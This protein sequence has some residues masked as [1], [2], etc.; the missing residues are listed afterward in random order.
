MQSII[1]AYLCLA[2]SVPILEAQECRPVYQGTL[3]VADGGEAPAFGSDVVLTDDEAFVGAQAAVIDGVQS[4]AVYIYALVGGAWEWVGRI[5]PPDARDGQLF[6]TWISVDGDTMMIGSPHDDEMGERSGSV[7]VYERHDGDWGFV[8]KLLPSV[9]K[10]L[11][12]F[13]YV[14]HRGG[15]AVI[16][17]AAKIYGDIEG[18][19][20][21]FE[22]DG[23]EWVETQRLT[24]SDG[25]PGEVFGLSP[26]FDDDWLMMGAPFARNELSVPN[27]ACY[28]FRRQNGAWV[29]TQVLEPD[30]FDFGHT[31]GF[32][33]ALEGGRLLVGDPDAAQHQGEVVAYELDAGVWK[34]A[35]VI[36]PEIDGLM[37]FGN[38][39]AMDGSTLLIGAPDSGMNA[40]AA[41]MYSLVEGDWVYIN[42]VVHA[43]SDGLSL[44]GA[45]LD[46]NAQTMMIAAPLD[47]VDAGSVY[48]YRLVCE[49]CYADLNGDGAMN[50]ADVGVFMAAF[51][52]G[53]LIADF[54]LDGELDFFDASAFLVAFNAGCP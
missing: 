3:S 30:V 42:T 52:A 47:D 46:I 19:A 37:G 44:F 28:V 11:G 50:A 10:E 26:V 25:G 45:M 39:L 15:M 41:G 2:V 38:Q 32:D 53:S 17:A 12:A 29:E 40:G 6:G 9:G 21:V 16:G 36:M 24:A 51:D 5:V 1:A 49:G 7:Y 4:G 33:L 22:Y 31:F 43:P 8:Q 23:D 14:F 27:G 13:G 48:V 35:Q 54:T 34:Q 20:Y 18:A